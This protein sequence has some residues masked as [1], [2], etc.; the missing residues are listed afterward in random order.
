MLELWRNCRELP[1]TAAGQP[2][3]EYTEVLPVKSIEQARKLAKGASWVWDDE[4]GEVEKI[5]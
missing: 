2:R 4:T 5:A 1:P 3:I